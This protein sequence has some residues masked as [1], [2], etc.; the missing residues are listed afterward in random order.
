MIL[1][2]WY[3]QIYRRTPL[4]T[5]PHTSQLHKLG[6]LEGTCIK[7]VY[8][9][10]KFIGLAPFVYWLWTIL[11]LFLIFLSYFL[12]FCLFSFFKRG[13]PITENFRWKHP[14]CP[15]SATCPLPHTLE[16]N[17]KVIGYILYTNG[18]RS[19]KEYS[20]RI[21]EQ[22]SPRLPPN[23]SPYTYVLLLTWITV[24]NCIFQVLLH[25]RS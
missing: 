20:Y 9:L 18:L 17:Q 1:P 13:H 7:G 6:H 22:I 24:Y 16:L 21:S 23:F 5:P 2:L 15:T 19:L 11:V 12:H 4:S 14:P 3:Y 8:S 25:R 10:G